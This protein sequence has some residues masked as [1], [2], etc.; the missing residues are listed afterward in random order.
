MS[1]F[2]E[3]EQIDDDEEEEQRFTQNGQSISISLPAEMVIAIDK[4]R[5]L[6][7]RSNWIEKDL[8][9]IYEEEMDVI[10]QEMMNDSDES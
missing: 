8:L 10:R 1:I 5:K 9:P 3:D 2:H 7:K 4:K 6:V